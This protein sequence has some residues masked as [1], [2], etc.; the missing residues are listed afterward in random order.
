VQTGSP[1]AFKECI[2]LYF[3]VYISGF[4]RSAWEAR[5]HWSNG[6]ELV[7]DALLQTLAAVR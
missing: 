5:Q 2:G 4:G 6:C 1:V 3:T 7:K